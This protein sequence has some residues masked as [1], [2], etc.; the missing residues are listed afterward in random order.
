MEFKQGDVVRLKSG[1]P[2]MTVEQIDAQGNVSCIWFQGSVVK[3][4]SFAAGLLLK[5]NRGAMA[6]YV[7]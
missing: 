3:K 2:D 6:F 4:Q 1:S 5:P 7:A